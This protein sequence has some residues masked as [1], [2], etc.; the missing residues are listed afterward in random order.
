MIAGKKSNLRSIE[1]EDSALYHRWIND[2]E[3]N[4][5]RGLYH[6]TNLEDAK[7]YIRAQSHHT[8]DKLTLGIETL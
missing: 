4:Y 6:P 1:N 5:W 2:A 7:D 8:P 3:T